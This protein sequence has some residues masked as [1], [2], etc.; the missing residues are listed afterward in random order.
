[1][2]KLVAGKATLEPFKRNMNNSGYSG[3]C[4]RSVLLDKRSR[5]LYLKMA[6][7]LILSGVHFQSSAQTFQKLYSNPSGTFFNAQ[8]IYSDT[9]Q[10]YFITGAVQGNRPQTFVLK[11]TLSGQMVW[12]KTLT[13]A[14]TSHYFPTGNAIRTTSDNGLIISSIKEKNGIVSGGILIKTTPAGEPEWSKYAPCIWRNSKVCADAGHVYYASEGK[15]I[16]KAYLTKISNEGQVLWEQW[17]E[18]GDMDFYNVESLVRCGNGD[19]VLALLVSKFEGGALI[20]PEQTVLFRIDP[21]GTVQQVAFFPVV[22]LAALTPLSDGRIAFRCSASDVTWTGMGVMDEQFNWL[23]FKKS[24]CS[25]TAFLPNIIGQELAVS[26]DES[27]ISGIFYTTGGEKVALTFDSNGELQNQEVYFSGAFAE[28]ATAARSKGYVRV[29]GIRADAFSITSSDVDGSAFEDCFFPD[30]CGLQLRDTL[31]QRAPIIWQSTAAACLEDE[32]AT[33]AH[34]SLTTTDFCVDPGPMH[35]GFTASDTV[36]CAGAGINFKRQAGISEP[37]FGTSEWSFE[38]GIPARATGATVENVH[39]N[40]PGSYAVRHI[41]TVAGCR[42]TVMARV[43]VLLPPLLNLG[44]DTTLCAGDTL[45]LHA[46]IHT[47]AT[48][49]WS[50]GDSSVSASVYRPGL[51]AVTVTPSGGCT[52]TDDIQVQFLTAADI[53]LGA[54]TMLCPDASIRLSAPETASNQI[55]TWSNG[56]HGTT[57]DVFTPGLYAL[58]LTASHCSFSDTI[59]VRASDCSECRV[60]AANVFAPESGGPGN[61]FQ[62][63]PGCPFLAGRWRIYDRWGA[64]LFESNDLNTGWDGRLNGKLLPPGVYLYDA[65]LQLSPVQRPVEWRRVSGSVALVR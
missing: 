62:L 4:T 57:L 44:A 49:L 13:A 37:V 11:T 3:N 43:T 22:H 19:L 53:F 65:E 31:L 41:F 20:G 16:R 55:L 30:A 48:Y 64:L 59:L 47:S 15:G 18:A 21:A 33:S 2:W 40:Q 46:D 24:R 9:A 54:D 42:D 6:V 10:G 5:F 52:A 63:F 32:S 14:D 26:S 17:L 45:L 51:F 27:L 39:F 60:Y 56:A 58:R 38:G 25:F 1:M 35:A 28:Q 61:V 8:D 34:F 29:S 50:T 23:W 36:I 7:V 12:S